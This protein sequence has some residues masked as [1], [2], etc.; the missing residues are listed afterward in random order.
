M[1]SPTQKQNKPHSKI[2]LIYYT[3][4][5][6]PKPKSKILQRQEIFKN[7]YSFIPFRNNIKD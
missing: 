5:E 6:Y 7:A 4:D 1:Q 2:F 3:Q